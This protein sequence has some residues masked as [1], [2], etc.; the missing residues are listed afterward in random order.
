MRRSCAVLSRSSLSVPLSL[1]VE[2]KVMFMRFFFFTTFF[3]KVKTSCALLG[4]M[5]SLMLR[6]VAASLSRV[7]SLSRCWFAA[8]PATY[9]SLTMASD[10]LLTLVMFMRSTS[11]VLSRCDPLQHSTSMPLMLTILSS[12]PGTAG[13]W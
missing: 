13:P 6:T 7:C 10:I 5:S 1:C 11:A 3:H 9:S 2:V 4:T 8:L 12:L